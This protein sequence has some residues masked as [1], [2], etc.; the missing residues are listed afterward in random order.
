MSKD[1]FRK[2]IGG[3]LLVSLIA[4]CFAKPFQEYLHIP[5]NITLFE[6]Q[7]LEMSKA[8]QVSAK[9]S[10]DHSIVALSQDNQS[11][12]LQAKEKGKM[13]CF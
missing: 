3:I 13:K 10:S 11:V 2:L 12:S 9:L 6:G 5:N 1:F 4:I 7:Q 8:A